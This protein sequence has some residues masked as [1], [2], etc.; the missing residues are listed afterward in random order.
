MSC[1]GV[2]KCPDVQTAQPAAAM[3]SS[4]PGRCREA[5]SRPVGLSGAWEQEERRLVRAENSRAKA[6]L[7]ACAHIHLFIFLLLNQSFTQRRLRILLCARNCPSCGSRAV[8]K[9]S[10]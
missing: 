2:L 5:F 10:L 1:S 8:E 6:Q 7:R 4:V 9:S 3:E